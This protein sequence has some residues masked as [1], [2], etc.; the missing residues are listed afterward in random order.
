M[1]VRIW[2]TE[3]TLAEMTPEQRKCAPQLLKKQIHVVNIAAA[4]LKSTRN[5]KGKGSTLYPS[6]G[7]RRQVLETRCDG[8]LRPEPFHRRKPAI[9][10]RRLMTSALQAR[11]Q[12]RQ[13]KL[14]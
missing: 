11:Q 10:D 13:G 2:K 8:S 6:R 3:P 9:D 14:R 5:V 7:H 1:I 4:S 12:E